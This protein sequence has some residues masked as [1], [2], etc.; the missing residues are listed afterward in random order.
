MYLSDLVYFD[1]LNQV[2]MELLEEPYPIRT[3]VQVEALP[4]QAFVEIEAVARIN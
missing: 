4:L 1:T 3:V 2:M